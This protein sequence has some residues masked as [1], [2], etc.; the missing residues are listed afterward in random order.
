MSHNFTPE[1][2]RILTLSTITYKSSSTLEIA[3][4]TDELRTFILQNYPKSLSKL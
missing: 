3:Q 4:A 2:E 1:D